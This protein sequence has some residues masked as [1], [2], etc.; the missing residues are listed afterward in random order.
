MCKVWLVGDVQGGRIFKRQ[1]SV[2]GS[3]LIL[4]LLYLIMR[5]YMC[6][7]GSQRHWI[8]LVLESH[9]VA[10]CPLGARK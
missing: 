10:A 8:T 6:A 7:H 5:M 2:G 1:G 3:F 4:F 9:T